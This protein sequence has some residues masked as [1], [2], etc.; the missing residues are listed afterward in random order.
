MA[1]SECTQDTKHHTHLG[2]ISTCR[3]RPLM[4]AACS[5]ASQAHHAHRCHTPSHQHYPCCAYAP[6]QQ[7]HHCGPSLQSPHRGPNHMDPPAHS[8]LQAHCM[9]P[10]TTHARA[11]RGCAAHCGTSR[12]QPTVLQ[13]HTQ[14]CTSSKDAARHS[15]QPRGHARTPYRA[16]SPSTHAK[17]CLVHPPCCRFTPSAATPS[18][19]SW[20]VAKKG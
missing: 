12:T 2:T 14:R 19:S 11:G 1:G 18:R 6:A 7:A 8:T 9:P 20:W 16:R 17:G 13:R 15:A 10:S 4:G 3:V 5:P